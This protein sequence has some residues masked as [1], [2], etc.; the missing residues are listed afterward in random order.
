MLTLRLRD[1]PERSTQ[2]HR[3]MLERIRAGDAD[4]VR[5][6]FCERRERAAA[7]LLGVIERLRP[8]QP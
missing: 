2:D 5:A 4:G 7:G 6:I 3:A 8:P 1:K